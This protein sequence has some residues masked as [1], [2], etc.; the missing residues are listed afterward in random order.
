[1]FDYVSLKH[2]EDTLEET[3]EEYLSRKRTLHSFYKYTRRAKLPW[4]GRKRSQGFED[5]RSTGNL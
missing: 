1:M 5:V 2:R 3:L 4:R